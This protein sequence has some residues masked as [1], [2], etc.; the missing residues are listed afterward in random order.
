MYRLL[1][2]AVNSYPAIYTYT[3]T[4]FIIQDVYTDINPDKKKK[5]TMFEAGPVHQVVIHVGKPMYL[6]ISVQCIGCNC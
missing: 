2:M 5:M 6:L 3:H 4:P 1:L